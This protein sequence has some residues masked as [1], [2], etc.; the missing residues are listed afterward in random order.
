M[1]VDTYAGQ[2]PT[3][4]SLESI[5]LEVAWRSQ[6]VMNPRRDK[7]SHYSNDAD[8]IYAQSSAGVVSVFNAETG[9]RLWAR[10]V[11][12]TDE[13]SM[14]AVSNSDTVL[15][16]AGP[17]GWGL[18]KLTGEVMF[19][20]RLRHH[21]SAAPA[22]DSGACYF[23]V[24]GGSVHAYALQTLT[25]QER[26][27]KL[28]PGVAQPHLWRFNLNEKIR[29][30]LVS[31]G[32]VLVFGTQ[33][34]NLYSISP[35][36]STYYQQFLHAGASAPICID[37]HSE[38][39]AVVVATADGNLYSFDLTRGTREWNVPLERNVYQQPLA[40]AGNV[41]FIMRAAGLAAVSTSTG[42]YIDIPDEAGDDQRWF[43][44]G[45]TSILAVAG[46]YIY[47]LDGN[48]RVVAIDKQSAQIIDR[49]SVG[50]FSKGIR[51]AVTDR[52]LLSSSSGELI[53]LKPAGSRFAT[54]HQRPEDEP[55]EVNIPGSDADTSAETQP[56]GE[57]P[58]DIPQPE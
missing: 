29:L 39:E 46:D 22:I 51:N 32:S 24:A 48:S 12:H 11:G 13:V 36:G 10:Q 17:V 19:E 42:R 52:I 53:C 50:R 20:H 47:G 41:Y 7:L 25:Y 23:P 37:S 26:Y 54:F 33:H 3:A 57:A 34:D 16:V 30:P 1:S 58:D 56:A 8:L 21:P 43:V 49:V 35:A 44:R 27:S 2:L 5:G 4:A 18:N 40:I 28:P 38:R 45:I 15:I 31:T 9:R 55:L 14:Q 6:A